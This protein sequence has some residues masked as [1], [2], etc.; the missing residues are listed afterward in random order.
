ML[1][2]CYRAVI[3]AVRAVVGAGR[4]LFIGGKSMGGRIATQVAAADPERPIAG[5][6]LLYHRMHCVAHI[7]AR[8]RSGIRWAI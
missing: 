4:P 1:E 2:A 5:L 6:V 7:W 3:E 8:N